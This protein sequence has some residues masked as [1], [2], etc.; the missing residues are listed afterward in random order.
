MVELFPALQAKPAGSSLPKRF[1][2]I[3]DVKK[4]A[5]S[6][7]YGAK[8]L[9]IAPVMFSEWSVSSPALL[10]R[11][12]IPNVRLRVGS[13]RFSKEYDEFMPS[14]LPCKKK[15]FTDRSVVVGLQVTVLFSRPK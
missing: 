3:A 11:Y 10:D 7:E 15:S 6:H 2:A 5:W 14:W 8:V 4:F 9:E 12:E 13:G 1:W